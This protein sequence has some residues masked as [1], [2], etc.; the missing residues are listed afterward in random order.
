M[1]LPC[2]EE[3]GVRAAVPKRHAEPLRVAERDV[4][5][6]LAWRRQQDEAQKIRADRDRHAGRLRRRD[7]IAQVMHP[8]GIVR[9]LH[10]RAEYAIAERGRLEIA[11]DQL[12]AERRRA[13]D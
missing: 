7:E 8:A 2:G 11:D 6:H 5:A 1:L 9:G 12:D 13:R 4:R 10:E 3:R